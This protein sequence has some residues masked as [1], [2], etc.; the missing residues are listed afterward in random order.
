LADNKLK[1]IVINEE[2]VAQCTQSRL[3]LVWKRGIPS[4]QLTWLDRDRWKL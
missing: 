4:T 3:M 1:K 2:T